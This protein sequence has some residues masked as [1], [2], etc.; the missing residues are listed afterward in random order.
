MTDKQ[1]IDTIATTP[2]LLIRQAHDIKA[3]LH[4]P[5]LNPIDSLAIIHR[6]GGFLV[7]V[8]AWIQQKA[9]FDRFDDR[10]DLFVKAH[11]GLV[12]ST[13]RALVKSSRL[14]FSEAR[15]R[16]STVANHL[17]QT[18]QSRVAGINHF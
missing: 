16:E 5:A 7:E 11:D 3:D 9:F 17:G 13:W 12:A 10:F 14:F 6:N 2:N 18:C 1:N 15:F 4:T 8:T